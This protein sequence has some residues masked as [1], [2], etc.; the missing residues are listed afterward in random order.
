MSQTR[1]WW[2]W[3]DEKAFPSEQEE[4]DFVDAL[5]RRYGSEGVEKR[6]PVS[7]EMANVPAP[8]LE[9]PSELGSFGTA[10]RRERMRRARGRSYPD[11]VRGYLGDFST[12]PDLVVSPRNEEEIVR[13][14]EWASDA[15]AAV[16]PYGGGSSVAGGVDGGGDWARGYAGVICLDLQHLN[17]VLEVDPTSRAARIQA[18]ALGP[19]LERQLAEHGYTLRHFPQSFEFSTLGGWLAT[20]AGGHYATMYTHIDD[21]TES[22]RVVTPTGTG[23]SLRVPGSG[24]GPSPDRLLLGSEGTLGV[25]TEAW[26]RVQ[27][28]PRHRTAAGVRFATFSQGAAAT[29]AISQA[30]LFPTNC[31][32]LEVSEAD[33]TASPDNSSGDPA[34][35]LMLAFESA[36]HPVDAW[37]DRALALCRE[38]G[39]TLPEGVQRR[40]GEGRAVPDAAGVV[41]T[42]KRQF[43]LTPYL[44]ATRIMYG[45]FGE[46]YETACTWDVFPELRDD[47]VSSAMEVIDKL[48]AGRG[49]LTCRFTHVYPDGPAPY[50]TVRAMTGHG[51]ELEMH[52]AMEAAVQGAFA[53]HGATATHHH[54]IGRSR[55]QWYDRQ[56]P[57]F[58]VRAMRA[59]KGE[60]DPHWTLNPG[61]LFDRVPGPGSVA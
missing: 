49:S 50:F 25:I 27:D 10:D 28:R 47:V 15:G 52:D 45:I 29:R 2:A 12:A 34:A 7:I 46:T 40:D 4:R 11:I 33:P 56:R 59:A 17:Q 8:R 5:V 53:R 16:V 3:G 20:R 43:I 32:L 36:D 60:L 61:V 58:M 41:G 51:K 6:P 57:D 1:S 55:R 18:G 48:A 22:I 13:T 37:M 30:G 31:R 42:W 54:A 44:I 24:A 19:H 21:L 14:L 38:Y 9:L 35:V 39:G 26:M 23:A